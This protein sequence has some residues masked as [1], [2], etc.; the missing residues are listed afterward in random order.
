MPATTSSSS[1]RAQRADELYRDRLIEFMDRYVRPWARLVRC[2]ATPFPPSSA[3]V[4]QDDRL[5]CPFPS[6]PARRT[7]TLA[8]PSVEDLPLNLLLPLSPPSSS[9]VHRVAPSPPGPLIQRLVRRPPPPP[10]LPS[11]PQRPPP[12]RRPAG[13][14]PGRADVV[15]S[16]VVRV[17]RLVRVRRRA[18]AGRA[19]GLAGG[20]R[21]CRCRYGRAGDQQQQQGRR[22]ER[23]ELVLHRRRPDV[24]VVRP[25][26]W[27]VRRPLVPALAPVA[28]R[29]GPAGVRPARPGILLRFDRST[30]Q[31]DRSLPI[32]ASSHRLNIAKVYEFCIRAALSLVSLPLERRL[33]SSG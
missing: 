29:R 22:Q 27:P 32:P 8:S 4:S 14:D 12:N 19:R 17:V 7:L 13:R 16:S 20:H 30:R 25:R 21:R 3:R 6:R 1:R 2:A 11:L 28:P 31:T 24:S 9:T 10:P 18:R 23:L 5:A 33:E 26:L 15:P